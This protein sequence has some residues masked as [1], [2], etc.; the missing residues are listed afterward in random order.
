MMADNEAMS[1][2]VTFMAAAIAAGQEPDKA[3]ETATKAMAELTKRLPPAQQQQ[4]VQP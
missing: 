2:W 4:Q 3:A 1:A